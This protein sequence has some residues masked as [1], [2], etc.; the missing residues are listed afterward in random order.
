MAKEKEAKER[1]GQQNNG[2]QRERE[3]GR[4]RV[5]G[6]KE[7]RGEGREERKREGREGGD[8]PAMGRKSRIRRRSGENAVELAKQKHVFGRSKSPPFSFVF[9]LIF[10]ID[11]WADVPAEQP[12]M[13]MVRMMLNQMVQDG[14]HQNLM[15]YVYGMLE[16]YDSSLEQE[17]EERTKELVEE[18]RKS[19]ILLYRMLPRQVADKLKLGE[20]VE[21][22]SFQMATIF[23]SDVVSFITLAG[24]CMP[25]R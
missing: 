6:G 21:P 14:N 19:D 3:E 8:G 25:C 10:V 1:E 22:E 17:V 11:C 18:K 24:K 9:A 15:D 2:G 12:R 13:D 16:Q 20:A 4:E 5:R 23:F 7:E